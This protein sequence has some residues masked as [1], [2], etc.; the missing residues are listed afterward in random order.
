MSNLFSYGY[1]YRR[2]GFSIES[3]VRAANMR[4][5]KEYAAYDVEHATLN[6]YS[7]DRNIGEHLTVSRRYKNPHKGESA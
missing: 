7:G 5:A 2:S 4:Q 3:T 6:P 1:I